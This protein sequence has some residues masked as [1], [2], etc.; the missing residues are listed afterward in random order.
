MIMSNPKGNE[1]SLTK[2]KPKW[3]KGTTQPI[4]V[5]A[6]IAI[7]VLN[8][9]RKL[10]EAPAQVNEDDEDDECLDDD[11]EPDLNEVVR[12]QAAKNLKLVIENR[13][14]KRE[15]QEA[16]ETVARVIEILE[17]ILLLDRFTKRHRAK[18]KNEVVE[19]LK[20]LARLI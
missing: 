15:A 13:V 7:E 12:D 14:L 8:Y 2:F 5:P 6:A 1:D 10:D 16:K 3:N 4:R 18:V 20:A 17:I 11:S 19:P 9:A